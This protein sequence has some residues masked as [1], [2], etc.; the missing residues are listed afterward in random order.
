MSF[1][2]AVILFW[3]MV[4][5][6]IVWFADRLIFRRKRVANADAALRHFDAQAMLRDTDGTAAGSDPKA[7]QEERDKLR[8]RLVRQPGWIEFPAG[9]F[10][11]ILVVFILRSFLFE[12]FRIPS[13]SMIPTLL[14]G[15]LILVNKFSYG[16]RLPIINKK[17]IDI[18]NPQRGDVM[19]FRYPVD[20]SVDYVKRV[21]G[22]PG[23]TVEFRAKRLTINGKPVETVAAPD[24]FD[25]DRVAYSKQFEEH[26]PRGDG[27][28]VHPILIDDDRSGAISPESY[29]SELARGGHAT[30]EAEFRD[31]CVFSDG[32]TAVTCKVPQGHYFMMGDN[33]DNSADSR[34][35][36]FVPD[37]NIVGH[38][39]LIWM[40]FGN[41]SR[42]G[43]FR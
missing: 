43:S 1:N 31:N 13:G 39:I 28:A 19:V 27:Y 18:G 6:G 24:Y 10:P 25:Q 30:E 22:L 12:P 23:D 40:N 5:T 26:L 8:E 29:L 11:V 32:N 21:I 20:P 38:A 34:Y 15:D 42:I 35:W 3:L 16:I 4:G 36:G 9:F 17:V 41:I 33:R 2:F 14:V 7:I 37:Q